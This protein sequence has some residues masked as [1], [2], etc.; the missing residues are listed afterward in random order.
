[1]CLLDEVVAMDDSSIRCTT[2]SHRRPDNPLRDA[3]RLGG[4]CALEY[5]G[6]AIAL[7][8]ALRGSGDASPRAGVI[9]AVREFDVHHA[10][11]DELEEDLLIECHCLAADARTLSYSFTV[12]SGD[13][14]IATGRLTIVQGLAGE[15]DGR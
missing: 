11:L 8:A 3:G 9:A 5:A 12:H 6:Q 7:H 2:G 4:A 15:P 1:M 13:V 14:R 10:R